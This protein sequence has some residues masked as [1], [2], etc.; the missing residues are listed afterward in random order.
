M[1]SHHGS[2]V[3][4]WRLCHPA[5]CRGADTAPHTA[6]PK[7]P[8]LECRCGPCYGTLRRR[9]DQRMLLPCCGWLPGKFVSSRCAHIDACISSQIWKMFTDALSLTVHTL[10]ACSRHPGRVPTSPRP[11]TGGAGRSYFARG[12]GGRV[13]ALTLPLR[14]WSSPF[15]RRGT[16]PPGGPAFLFRTTRYTTASKPMGC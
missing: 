11:S 9:S 10:N 8:S 13:E 2:S 4:C 16:L 6:A 12:E 1:H 14:P 3:A 7:L 5:H 15:R